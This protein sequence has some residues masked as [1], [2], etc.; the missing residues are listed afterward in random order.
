MY[1][2]PKFTSVVW[3]RDGKPIPTQN[4]AKYKS[5]SSRTIVKDKIHGREVQLDGYNVT[6]TIRDLK[7]EDFVNYTVTL[8]SGYQD[9]KFT[10]VFESASKY[11]IRR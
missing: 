6:L 4:S 10:I 2:V 7:A 9:V 1:S 5:S 8:K 3:T 11:K